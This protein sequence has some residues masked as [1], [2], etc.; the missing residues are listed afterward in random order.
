M[1]GV[2]QIGV[3]QHLTSTA[4]LKKSWN[5]LLGNVNHCSGWTRSQV[6]RSLH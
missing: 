5:D 3:T 2:V 1:Q 6:R 4:L